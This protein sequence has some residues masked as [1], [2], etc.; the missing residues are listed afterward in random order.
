MF[1]NRAHEPGNGRRALPALLIALAF[2][3]AHCCWSAPAPKGRSYRGREAIE[4]R[5]SKG[6][7]TYELDVVHKAPDTEFRWY[8]SPESVKDQRV[9]QSATEVLQYIPT[10]PPRLVRISTAAFDP[11]VDSDMLALMRRN[12]VICLQ[13]MG[14]IAGRRAYV[15]NAS[16]KWQ[17]NGDPSQTRYIDRETFVT[18]ATEQFGP[19]V[20]D[21]GT[22][23]DEQRRA[24]R[25]SVE[26]FESIEFPSQISDAE[27]ELPSGGAIVEVQAPQMVAVA[28]VAEFAKH[29]GQFVPRIPMALP[30]GYMME[31]AVA[32]PEHPLGS[33]GQV[34]F[35]NG[36]GVV[37]MGFVHP[38]SAD[39]L[40]RVLQAGSQAEGPP[41]PV[42]GSL[43]MSGKCVD[44]TLYTLV[45]N[46]DDDSIKRLVDSIDPEAEGRIIIRISTY[47]GARPDDIIRLR[48][49]GLGMQ[50]AHFIMR[51][52]QDRGVPPDDLFKAY[53][54]MC[55]FQTLFARYHADFEK[56]LAEQRRILNERMW[57]TLQQGQPPAR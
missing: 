2:V 22:L 11:T 32:M 3:S 26:R 25:L 8:R 43:R 1:W 47:T 55:D 36:V 20:R 35:T 24:K 34:F 49:A 21:P 41:K 40:V 48:Q 39:Q 27:L 18:L 53:Q 6:P 28:S 19:D 44:N 10:D 29:L 33:G 16:P 23:S 38:Q 45:A 14:K 5:T 52:S 37:I 17:W 57:F 30:P 46:L 50:Q 4:V 51:L 13:R 15:V 54:D 7:I 42:M 31:Q 56:A 9:R 12:Y